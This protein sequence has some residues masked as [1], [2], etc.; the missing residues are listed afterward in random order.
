[1]ETQIPT[2][3]QS[4]RHSSRVDLTG[5]SPERV[6]EAS[7]KVLQ[8]TYLYLQTTDNAVNTSIRPIFQGQ[9]AEWQSQGHLG[10]FV[11]AIPKYP[12]VFHGRRTLSSRRAFDSNGWPRLAA[13][14]QLGPHHTTHTGTG[15]LA[16][17]LQIT[18][19]SHQIISSLDH[20]WIIETGYGQVIDLVG[21]RKF[22][23]RQLQCSGARRIQESSRIRRCVS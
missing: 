21:C 6:R 11:F 22:T 23:R 14:S 4:L 5:A 18:H 19:R 20:S 3:L 15:M 9:T 12:L 10:D 2:D 13:G 17:H 16:R 7:I 1:M 8:T